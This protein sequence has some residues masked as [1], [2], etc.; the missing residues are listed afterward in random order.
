MIH[1]FRKAFTL[2]ELL[3]V[4]AIIGILAAIAVPNFMNA[5]VRATLSRNYADMRSVA[6]ALEAYFVDWNRYPFPSDP[7]GRI[8]SRESPN[9]PWFETKLPHSLTTP[10][11]YISF[12]PLDP[13]HPTDGENEN[14]V[15][16]YMTREYARAQTGSDAG[17]DLYSEWMGIP[18]GRT[19]YKLLGH[20][21]DRSHL[22]PDEPVPPAPYHA[23]NG[24]LSRG[25]IVFFG[26][27]MSF[28][29]N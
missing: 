24:L 21:P 7:W 13:F 15:Y 26:P 27:G 6:T 10:I 2:I 28:S 1:K 14:Q 20:G 12:W 18:R 19:M 9:F 3:I 11:A 16:H 17:Y 25:D 8:I 4:V 23:S 5:Q 22:E 29:G